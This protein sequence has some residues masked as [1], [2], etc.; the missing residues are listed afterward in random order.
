[1]QVKQKYLD[2]GQSKRIWGELYKVIDSSDV[3]IQVPPTPH[4]HDVSVPAVPLSQHT[5]ALRM[6][7][8]THVHRHPTHTHMHGLHGAQVTARIPAQHSTARPARRMLTLKPDDAYSTIVHAQK[9]ACAC[10]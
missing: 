7:A 6:H 2:K 10:L 5:C 1:M 3:V 9:P 8:A 4:R